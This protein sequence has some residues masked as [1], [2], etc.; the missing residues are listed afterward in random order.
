MVEESKAQEL[1]QLPQ[2]ILC[3]D[4]EIYSTALHTKEEFHFENIVFD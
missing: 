3:L 2:V 4:L 1:N